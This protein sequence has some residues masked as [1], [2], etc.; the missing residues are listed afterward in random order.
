MGE[1]DPLF[2]SQAVA[3][4]KGLSASQAFIDR[5]SDSNPGYE[6]GEEPSS[7]ESLRPARAPQQVHGD[8]PASCT[9]HPSLITL[10]SRGAQADPMTFIIDEDA[11]NIN[12]LPSDLQP[13]VLSHGLRSIACIPIGS[14]PPPPSAKADDSSPLFNQSQLLGCLTIGSTSPLEWKS[15]GWFQGLTLL[16]AWTSGVLSNH[17]VSTASTLI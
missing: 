10:V 1:P 4:T 11:S 6:H 7:R 17:R 5:V 3:R 2:L 9:S 16:M 14:G 15:Q 12:N 8:K 13:M